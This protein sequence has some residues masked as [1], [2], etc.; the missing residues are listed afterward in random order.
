MNLPYLHLFHW[1]SIVTENLD[2][3]V[4][5]ADLQECQEIFVEPCTFAKANEFANLAKQLGQRLEF[6]ASLANVESNGF[7]EFREG[8][9]LA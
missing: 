2:D 5:N 1:Q 8:A 4:P 6:Q 9:T 7:E 3:I